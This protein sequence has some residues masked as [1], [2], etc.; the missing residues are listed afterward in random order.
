MAW[1]TTRYERTMPIWCRER[2]FGIAFVILLFSALPAEAFTLAAPKPGTVVA[3]GEPL[4]VSVKAGNGVNLRWVKFYWYRSDEEP[5]ASNQADPAVFTQTADAAPFTGVITVPASG[6][7]VMR[8]LAV[9]EVSKGRLGGNEDFDEVLLT[10]QPKAALTMIEFAVEKP[11]RLNTI[12]KRVLLP[13]VGQFA[14]EG[15]RPLTGLGTE[16]EFWSSDEG[17]ISVDPDGTVQVK[18]NGKAI[19]TVKNRGKEG[20]LTIL[21]N[22]DTSLNHEPIARVPAELTVKSGHLVVLDGLQSRDPDGD[23]LRYEWKQLR[24]NK[25]PLLNSN[26]AKASFM[27]PSV[28]QR[29]QLQFSLQVTDMTGPDTVKGADSRP[30]IISVWVDP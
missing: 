24:G 20:R 15:V 11:W 17:V 12:G 3:P 29:R 14:D 13:A 16:S 28:V 23:P 2:R 25:V 7:G 6:I 19:V 5:V 21:V 30:A 4:L 1:S 10:V 18:G 26:D 9:G 27:A 22:G 8:L